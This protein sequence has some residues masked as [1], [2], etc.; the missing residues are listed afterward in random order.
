VHCERAR[1]NQRAF[2]EDHMFNRSLLLSL[3]VTLLTFA[4]VAHAGAV[5]AVPCA[6]K[7]K[8]VIANVGQSL[9]N[10]ASTVTGDVQAGTTI[11]KNGNAVITGTQTPK[12]PAGLAVVPAPA[13]ATNLGNFVV[14]GTVTLPAGNYVA[15]SFNMNGGSTL[16]VSGLV[17]IWVSGGV[18]LTGTAN[19]GGD[20]T[21]LELLLTGNQGVNVNSNTNFTGF[22]YSPTGNVLIGATVNG[23]VVGSSTTLNSGG[24]V[25]FVS[26]AVCPAPDAGQ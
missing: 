5:T 7:A 22:I 15:T 6:A 16:K 19:A 1:N 25:T 24:R 8:A 12:T 23:S 20:P 3:P 4:G 21:N 26:A 13:G 9:H 17:Q 2:Q 14:S 10:S 11:I 18:N